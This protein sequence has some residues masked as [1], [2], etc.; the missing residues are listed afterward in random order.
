MTNRF[1]V[2]AAFGTH[3]SPSKMKPPSDKRLDRRIPNK[4]N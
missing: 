2:F 1:P 3:T 4:K